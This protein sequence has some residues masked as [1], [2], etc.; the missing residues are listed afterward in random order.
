MIRVFGQTDT[1][2]TTNGDIVLNPLKAKIHKEDNGAYFLDLETSLSYVDY[3]VEGNIVVANTPQGDQAFR[4]NNV[5]KTRKKITI[6]C[7]HVFYDTKNFLV[8]KSNIVDKTC[9]EAMNQVNN[10][11]EPQSI[12]E[13]SSDVSNIASYNCLRE[14]LYDAIKNIQE[15]WGGHIVRDNFNIQIKAEIGADN[16]VIIRYGKNLKDITCEENWNDVVTKMLPTGKNAIMLNS[17]D[18]NADIYVESDIQYSLP[19][20]KSVSFQQDNIKEEDYSTELAYT[21]ALVNDLMEKATN[22]VNENS[23]PKIN[24]ALQANI[25]G[26]TDVGDIIEVIDERLGINI[27]TSVISYD[28]DCI[29]KK[30]TEIEFGN[31][32]K[33]L[34]GLANNIQTAIQTNIKN[35]E[36]KISRDIITTS[37]ENNLSNFSENIFNKIE[38][39]LLNGEGTKL[40]KT[41]DGGVRIGSNTNKVIV[42]GRLT[43]QG[44]SIEGVRYIRLMKN[45]NSDDNVLAWEQQSFDES[46]IQ[47]L[48]ITPQVVTVNPG[49]IIYLWYKTPSSNDVVMADGTYC[50]VEAI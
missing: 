43:S 5:S 9:D 30:Y 3:L 8:V 27:L 7:N 48:S 6:K 47:T 36:P 15:K 49:D 33:S 17:I 32:K 26:I 10:S 34:S 25:D 50:T 21:Q 24:Y 29:L 18:P 39:N 41:D 44:S 19:Y 14:S 38:L 28:Y 1:D 45:F 4:I 2:F 37:L 11:T 20:T 46:K 31:F 22:Y 13:T 35:I 42:S 12:F 16:G 40:I 23:K